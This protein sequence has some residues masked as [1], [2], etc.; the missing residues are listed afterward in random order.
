M[1]RIDESKGEFLLYQTEDEQTRVQVRF[2]EYG[3]W[4]SQSQI[5]M[6]FQVSVKTIS[7]HLNNIFNEDELDSKRTIWNVQKVQME[8]SQS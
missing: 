7:E 8:H 3:L 4:L 6:L 5:A 2:F 1:Q